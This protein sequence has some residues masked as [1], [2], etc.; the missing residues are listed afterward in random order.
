MLADQQSQSLSLA[1]GLSEELEPPTSSGRPR[2]ACL[3]IVEGCPGAQVP[4]RHP[5]QA[6]EGA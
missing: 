1:V 4:S 5:P 6:Y 3:T 2:T